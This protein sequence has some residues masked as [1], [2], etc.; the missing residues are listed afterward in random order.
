MQLPPNKSVKQKRRH[1]T[2]S[3]IRQLAAS[4]MSIALSRRAAYLN[5]R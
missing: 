4:T 2:P 1:A 5:M 3:Y